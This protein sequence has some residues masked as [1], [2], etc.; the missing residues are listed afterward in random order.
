[1]RAKGRKRGREKPPDQTPRQGKAVDRQ[2][3]G[4]LWLRIGRGKWRRM[5]RRHPD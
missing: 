1:M 4:G 2:F 3:A 5:G